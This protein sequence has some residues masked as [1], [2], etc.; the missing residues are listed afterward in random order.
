MTLSQVRTTIGVL[1]LLVCLVV[2]TNAQTFSNPV[3]DLA[4]PFVVYHNG[5]YYLTGTTGGNVG[6]KKSATLQGLKA[7]PLQVVFTPQQGGPCCNY[8]APELHRLD[9]KWY[10]YYTASEV[11]PLT[12][13]RTFVIENSAAD[14]LAG[15]WISRGRIFD[16][17]ADYWAIDGTVLSLNNINYFIWSGVA[18]P[19]D[20]DKPQRIYIAR[21]S[22]PWT[23][24]AGRTLLSSPSLPWE[25]NGAVNEGPE[26]LRKNGK[27]FLVYSANGCWTAD[28]K[29]G[30]LSMNDTSNPLIASSWTKHANAV[31]EK[32]DAVQAYGPGHHGFFKSPNGTEDWFMYHATTVGGGACDHTRTDR[33]QKLTWNADGTPNF[34]VPIETG[35][36]LQAPAGEIALP[37]DAPIANGVYRIISKASQKVV[38][39][40]QCSPALGANVH[41]WTWNGG[42]CQKWNIQATGDGYYVITSLQGGLSMEVVGGSQNNGADVAQWAPNGASCQQWKI[43]ST[44]NGYH[45]FVARHSGKVLDLAGGNVADGT[46]IQQWEWL[47]GDPQQWKL[48]SLGQ[49]P[50]TPGVYRI[51][52]K[53]S[54]KVLD[55]A[56]CSTADGANVHQW[57]WLGGNCQ[58]WNVESTGDGYFRLVA[59]HSGK[60]L[61]VAGCST[62]A[63][64]NIHQWPWLG[65]DCQKFSI[66]PISNGYFRI[67]AKHSGLVVDVDNCSTA[68]GANV[69][70][71]IWWGGDCQLW[72]F[73]RVNNSAREAVALVE[74]DGEFSLYP[75]PAKSKD[76]LK[77]KKYFDKRGNVKIELRDVT[78]KSILTKSVVVESGT[79]EI[80]IALKEVVAGI[81][82]VSITEGSK[83]VSKRIVVE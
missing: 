69:K 48:E 22:N 79:Q 56:G 42:D 74:V 13:Q 33:A 67:V 12:G 34:G 55:V 18:T 78:S 25:N 41:Q 23:L 45:R 2:Q 64:A 14:P 17:S 58:R 72:R 75:N 80:A 11:S 51:V 73:D 19:N 81:Y 40:A 60:V 3:A 61:D 16:S 29:L 82:V 26:V 8:W 37:T 5:F 4:D 7:A 47:G 71:W 46:N 65:G 6:L 10:I 36:T 53:V 70:Q 54:D 32:N 28:Y 49:Q 31:F 68:N 66:E 83:V 43:E 27:V 30:M 77:I 44:G 50:I 15:T 20:G 62:T 57:T 24:V 1:C 76:Q 35:L 21:M 38:D 63:G 52:S 9:N 59:Q 39:V